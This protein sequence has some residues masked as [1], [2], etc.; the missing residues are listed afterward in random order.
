MKNIFLNLT[1]FF[2]S[3]IA[4]SCTDIE[5]IIYD[6]PV[7]ENSIKTSKDLDM[8]ILGM[9]ANL[10]SWSSFKEIGSTCAYADDISSLSKNAPGL[11]GQKSGL[12]SGTVNF[13]NIWSRFYQT[14]ASA[15]AVISYP[16][17]MTLDSISK[18]KAISEARFIRGFSYFYLVQFYGAVPIVSKV[19]DYQTDFYPKRDS[20]DLVYRFVFE[21]LKAAAIGLPLKSANSAVGRNRANKGSAQA[22]LAKAY[23]TYANYLDLNNKAL[24]AK[25][26][27]DS[28]RNVANEIITSN[29]YQLIADYRNL[30][31]ITKEADAYASEVIFG[32][33]Y[34]RDA[35]VTN[36]TSEG[37]SMAY[38]FNPVTRS[39][40]GGNG[41]N[42]TG[43]GAFKVQ[44]WFYEKY[45]TGE[46]AGDYRTEV[47]FLTTWVHATTGKTI[48]TFPILPPTGAVTESQPYINKYVDPNSSAPLCGE[49]DYFLLRYSEIYLILAEAEN[50]LNG[51]STVALDA[52]NKV[53]ER[54][55]KANGTARAVPVDLLSNDV[56]TK[57]DM[58]MKIFDER[59]LEFVGEINRWFDLIRMRYKDNIRTMYEYQFGTFI[60]SLPAGLPTYSTTTKKW[61]PGRTEITN[62]VPFHKKYLL[63][64]IPSNETG[65]NKNL[66]QNFGW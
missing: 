43:L 13:Y 50:E 25:L 49:N 32:I 38:N 55:R 18:S 44:P 37:S 4:V 40:S 9:Y 17:K 5:Q 54:A 58:R 8:A 22:Y 51:P 42:K 14:I 52:F 46:Y 23:L 24:D 39:N 57:E 29:Q 21:D 19:A 10:N 59:G 61:S 28:A 1:V 63:Y 65:V 31:D 36:V 15:N 30:W 56:P 60:P 62:I 26:Y 12:N 47:S 7:P 45:S 27:Y 2:I 20:V 35:T 53:R 6:T 34:T 3:L 33:A 41:T 11:F 48:V 64:P 16:E 66:D